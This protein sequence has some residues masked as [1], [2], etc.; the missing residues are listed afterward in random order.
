MAEELKLLIEDYKQYTSD[1]LANSLPS[2]VWVDGFPCELRITRRE[3]IYHVEYVDYD[4]DGESVEIE[5][6]GKDITIAIIRMLLKLLENGEC[7]MITYE[8]EK[9]GKEGHKQNFDVEELLKE[10]NETKRLQDKL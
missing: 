8:D 2:V 4:T 6:E 1:H 10:I 3:T 7:Y 9:E 5:A